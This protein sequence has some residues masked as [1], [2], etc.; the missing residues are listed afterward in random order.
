M[1]P[2]FASDAFNL[3]SKYNV[4]SLN[5]ISSSQISNRTT[6]VI[7]HL[8]TELA[9]SSKPVLCRLHAKSDVASKLISI[10]EIAKR[11]LHA[12]NI[13]VYQYS[14][15]SSE[16][17]TWKP[18]ANIKDMFKDPT[19]VEADA[20]EEREEDT[21]QTMPQKEKIRSVPVLTV[22]LATKSIKD[23]KA[24]LGYVL[25]LSCCKEVVL[26][27]K[28]GSKLPDDIRHRRCGKAARQAQV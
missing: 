21:F 2:D 22:Y 20:A 7:K 10:T 23:L 25:D 28:S 17:T 15:L 11:E 18:K 8:T 9:E 13:K 19:M 5:V 3:E 27:I 26:I 4:I 14:G 16:I 6:L 12:K 24:A 1:A